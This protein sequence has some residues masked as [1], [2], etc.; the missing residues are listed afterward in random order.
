MTKLFFAT[1]VH[2]SDICWKKFISAGK[3]YKADVLILGGDLTGKAIVPII[4][5]GGQSYR[6][7]LLEQ[8]FRLQG[9]EEICEM[10]KRI[11]SRGYY[12]YRTTPDE[13][14]ELEQ[15]PSR[16]ETL[17]TEQVLKTFEAWLTY[18]DE[19]LADTSIRCFVSPGNDDLFAL[20]EL[21]QQSKRVVL[22]EGRS[23]WLDDHHEMISTGWSTPTPWQ[24]YREESEESL[25][26]RIGEMLQKVKDPRRCVFN[27]HVPPYDSGLDD[28]PELT[29]D[30]RP[31]LAGN[32]LI[33]VGSRAVRQ[34]IEKHHPLLGFFG[35]IHE[36]RGAVYLER[37]LCINPGSTYEQGLLCGAL[38]SLEKDKVKS[39]VLTQG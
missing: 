12:P 33:P 20:D 35:H 17:F 29:T 5:T 30:L 4:S 15:N 6:A 19:K 26:V 2:G 16:V 34:S 37:T 18:A 3:F 25:S 36:G 39:H 10:E 24:T 9:E 14:Q 8:E 27:F 11:R 7:V 22:A 31:K 13:I 23:I 38:V 21:V 32:S 1:D 28:A